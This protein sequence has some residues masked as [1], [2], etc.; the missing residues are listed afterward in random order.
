MKVR[1]LTRTDGMG[2][3]DRAAL[4][5]H[6]AMRA[7]GVDSHLVVQ[8]KY[9][10]GQDVHGPVGNVAKA[11]SRLRPYLDSLPL[12]VRGLRPRTPF[13]V[14][15]MST[16][17]RHIRDVAAEVTHLHYVTD[18]FVRI[19]DL[20]QLG[21]PIVWT[22]HDMWPF[23]G[24]C[25]YTGGC[26]RVAQE[27]GRCPQLNSEKDHDLSWRGWRRKRSA[28]AAAHPVFVASSRWTLNQARQSSLLKDA[29][30]EHIPN[31][32][33]LR[34]FSPMARKLT[35]ERLGLPVK[36]RIILFLQSGHGRDPRKGGSYLLEALRHVT[37][38]GGAKD[39][40]LLTM[41]GFRPTA[42]E[43][44]G[45]A[46]LHVPRVRDEIS[47]SLYYAAADV[48][49]VPSVEDALPNVAMESMACGTPCIGFTIG[50]MP[51]LI[52]HAVDG[53]LAVER[54]ATDLARGLDFVLGDEG[55]HATLA[56]EARQSAVEKFDRSLMV[57]RH[58][59][60][61]QRLLNDVPTAMR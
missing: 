2:G 8:E 37:A 44:Q 12:W 19:E 27:C 47:L 56:S 30:I 33:D 4:R 20:P 1:H 15:W 23:T 29:H 45:V 18:G 26:T 35:R 16:P 58:L 38:L 10:D 55:R 13:N 11:V 53:Y 48:T 54:D 41:G 36:G 60:L 50:G 32:I 39:L 28:F 34:T 22:L 24:G 52:R 42:D 3:A 21:R 14:Q 59:R 6:E 57:D 46:G 31:G 49:A 43:L 9:A 7:A 40:T 61:Y 51:E 25:H 17:M 5:L